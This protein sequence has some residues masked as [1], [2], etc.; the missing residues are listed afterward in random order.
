LTPAWFGKHIREQCRAILLRHGIDGSIE[1]RFEKVSVSQFPGEG[2]RAVFYLNAVEM[3][4]QLGQND[5][6]VEV[7][8]DGKLTVTFTPHHLLHYYPFLG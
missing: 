4:L 2:D 6:S 3:P 5:E 8:R 7:M 1:D